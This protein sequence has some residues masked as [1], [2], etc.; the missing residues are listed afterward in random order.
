MD[1]IRD[2]LIYIFLGLLQGFTEP[3]PISSS[4]HLVIAQHLFN[5]S[6]EGLSFEVLV[7]FA[8][9][10]AILIIY[11]KDIS[12][13][14]LRAFV[15]LGSRDPELKSDFLFVLYLIIATIPAAFIGI[16][17][18]EFIS[19]SLKGM[20]TIGITL[21]VTGISLWII[22]NLKGSKNEHE[23]SIKDAIIVGVAQAVALI[24]GISRSGATIVA[25][26]GLGMRQETALK[27][28]FFSL[29]SG[30]YRGNDFRRRKFGK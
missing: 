15:F 9:L 23:L 26:M 27:F 2:V 25:A 14:T 3:L 6:I 12:R 13:L 17:L 4:G 16:L 5:L 29:Y 22:R 11:R 18:G 24:P 20:I 30:Q 28:S 1:F 10:I 8:S 19:E 7:N 21:I